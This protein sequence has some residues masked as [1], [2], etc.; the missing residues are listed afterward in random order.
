MEAQARP[1]DTRRVLVL[2]PWAPGREQTIEKFSAG[3]LSNVELLPGV[4]LD[5]RL[6][7]VAPDVWDNHYDLLLADLGL[8]LL[9]AEAESDGYDAV[10][11]ET[12]GDGG[13]DELRSL[14]RIP[15]VGAGQAA[16]LL[17]MQLGRTFSILV[18]WDGFELIHQRTLRRYG[19][20]DRC[21]SIRA[22]DMK[23][24]EPDFADMFGGREDRFYPALAELAQQCVD[25]DG[26]DVIVLGST[27]MYAAYRYLRDALD[28]PVI[29]PAAASY[30]A[31]EA[32]LAL[33]LSHSRRAYPPVT[34]PLGETLQAMHE[35][36]ARW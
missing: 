23:P 22:L 1:D 2:C 35:A 31:A 20:A 24:G 13:L 25:E 33:G 8:V 29:E 11:I 30:K 17:A 19:W 21:A 16:H 34:S 27:T 12:I 4:T 14:L 26:A 10:V 7:R 18:V 15:V 6:T 28:V 9:G 32:L 3:Q 5:F 36:G